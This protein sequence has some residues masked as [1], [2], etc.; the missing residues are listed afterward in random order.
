MSD[1]EQARRLG[2]YHDGELAGAARASLEEHLR[3][4]PSCAAELDRLRGLSHLLAGAA[5]PRI[6][7][8]TLVRL[9]RTA[10][11]QAMAGLWRMAE[12]AT[13]VAA[14]ILLACG[15][16]LWTARSA[17]GPASQMPIWE[18]VAVARQALPV[19]ESEERLARWIVQDLSRGNGHD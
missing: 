11:A 18:T 8:E 16:W 19:A 12:M 14:S 17:A 7:P 5:Q 1:C 4:C 2:A 10:D 13:A 3:R 15:I 6:S 9:H